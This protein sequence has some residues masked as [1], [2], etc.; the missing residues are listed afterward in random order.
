M[1]RR[2]ASG[3]D[4]GELRRRLGGDC[5][6]AHG[7]GRAVGGAGGG[8]GPAAPVAIAEL[9][10]AARLLTA[11]LCRP[12]RACGS[13]ARNG[14]GDLFFD[15]ASLAD[16]AV[17]ERCDGQAAI[18][19]D[20]RADAETFRLG[21]ATAV[22]RIPTR[23]PTGSPPTS[24]SPR[25]AA[26]GRRDRRAAPGG[27]RAPGRTRADAHLDRHADPHLRGARF[28]R[29]GGDS[30]RRRPSTGEREAHRPRAARHPGQRHRVTGN[31]ACRACRSSS[32]S[33]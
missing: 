21:P 8:R 19:L 3:A 11:G 18:T 15:P 16:V 5:G 23:P 4:I 24:R 12:A 20:P 14:S 9:A 10:A 25:R 27:G 26:H 30:S 33:A 28:S 32:R 7:P 31:E 1:R 13:R 2:L 29:A 6:D 17:L 22:V